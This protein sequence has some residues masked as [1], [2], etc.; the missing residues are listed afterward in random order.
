MDLLPFL[1]EL[2]SEGS[3][4]GFPIFLGHFILHMEHL[5]SPLSL[6]V[7]SFAMLLP[8]MFLPMAMTSSSMMSSTMMASSSHAFLLDLWNFQFIGVFFLIGSFLFMVFL[9]LDDGIF[10]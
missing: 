6:P 8:A 10:I 2:L 9:N 3:L 5:L 1:H 4:L 7:S